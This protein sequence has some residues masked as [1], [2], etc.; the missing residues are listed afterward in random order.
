MHYSRLGCQRNDPNVRIRDKVRRRLP[1]DSTSPPEM[2][3]LTLD[4]TS[5]LT[6]NGRVEP[7]TGGRVVGHDN[8]AFTGIDTSKSRNAVAIAF[9]AWN[10]RRLSREKQ[11]KVGAK[12]NWTEDNRAV[13]RR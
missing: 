13:I 10:Y 7:H 3:R 1:R 8:E 5:R 4:V 12:R 6:R 9:A 2:R 11:S